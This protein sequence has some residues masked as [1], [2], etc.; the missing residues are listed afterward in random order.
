MH[1][2]L[3]LE[4]QVMEDGVGMFLLFGE[5]RSGNHLIAILIDNTFFEG[6]RFIKWSREY[7]KELVGNESIEDG[8]IIDSLEW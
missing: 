5:F 6:I 1:Y 7:P 8:H 4:Y 3:Q 2:L